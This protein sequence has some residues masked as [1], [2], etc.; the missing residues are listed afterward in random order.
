MLSDPNP[1]SHLKTISWPI[2]MLGSG[3]GCLLSW[4]VLSG[5]LHGRVNLF[6]LLFLFLILPIVGLVVSTIS[7]LGGKGINLARLI[8]KLPLWADGDRAMLRRIHQLKVDKHWFFVQSQA[9]A[10]AFSL[11]SLC[12]YFL[13]LLITDINFVWRSTVLDSEDVLHILKV[14]ASPWLFWEA[15]QPT[16]ELLGQTQDSRVAISD[17]GLGTYGRWWQF[18]LATQLCYNLIPRGVL[19]VITLRWYQSR[20]SK[21]FEY[22]LQSKINQREQNIEPDNELDPIVNRLPID[23]MLNN[24][25]GV[26]LELL[27]AFITVTLDDKLLAGPLATDAEQQV[28]EGWQGEQLVIVKAWEPPLGELDDFLRKGRGFLMPVDW[29]DRGLIKPKPA[30]LQ[31]WQRFSNKLDHWQV[32]QPIELMNI[33]GMS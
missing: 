9:A 4:G 11:A 20:L 18:I 19:L 13:L 24:W 22:Q 3:L 6:Y 27:Q 15:A 1:D 32:F 14:V 10:L 8:S 21:D 33:K 17:V 12:V 5:D 31:E 25:A 16:I 2:V 30:H 7:M 28:A 23:I 26:N 29:D